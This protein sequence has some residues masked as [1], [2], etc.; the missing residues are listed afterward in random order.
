[1]PH[2]Q[3]IPHLFL[4]LYTVCSQCIYTCWCFCTCSFCNRSRL[5]ISWMPVM[6]QC[7]TILG[8]FSHPISLSSQP[9]VGSIIYYCCCFHFPDVETELQRVPAGRG[10]HQEG[11]AEGPF[12][13]KCLVRLKLLPKMNCFFHALETSLPCVACP[14][15]PPTSLY[16]HQ[17]QVPSPHPHGNP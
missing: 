8:A 13:S 17:S 3:I 4:S 16:S 6:W 14:P 9:Q 1:M 12:T 5:S 2:I 11:I 10:T 7:V 15:K